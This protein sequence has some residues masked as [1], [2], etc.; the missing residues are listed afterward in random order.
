MI[1]QQLPQLLTTDQLIDLSLGIKPESHIEKDYFTS[2]NVIPLGFRKHPD[3]YNDFN[4]PEEDEVNIQVPYN[5]TSNPMH[6]GYV[7][8]SGR[9]KT[10]LCKNIALS[11]QEIGY[12]LLTIEAKSND[13]SFSRFKGNGQILH[14]NQENTSMNCVNYVPSF[15]G[16]LDSVRENKRN[17]KFY[18]P[19]IRAFTNLE[20]WSNLGISVIA[21]DSVSAFLKKEAINKKSITTEEI[22]KE[23][24]RNLT[25]AKGTKNS[26]LT[27]L[28]NLKNLDFFSYPNINFTEEWKK[29]RNIIVSLYGQMGGRVNVC[30]NKL[31][32]DVASIGYRER[33]ISPNNVSGKFIIFEDCSFYAT[34]NDTYVT[35]EIRNV[36]H[37]MRA[38]GVNSMLVIQLPELVEKV[39]LDGTSVKIVGSINNP[40][41]IRG[42][43]PKQAYEILKNEDLF[44]DEDNFIFEKLLIQGSRIKRFFQ[45]DCRCNHPS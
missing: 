39:T 24:R 28:S 37:N 14:R 45:W 33:S 6:I 42:Q 18:S 25:M 1:S 29:R 31:I 4:I 12:N 40:E 34:A 2:K 3:E 35:Q 30:V 38:V 22:E 8:M 7:D 10:Q 11:L 17:L 23:I 41:A 36:H 43:I 21:S 20:D 26:A 16:D 27:A 9:R 19:S 5:V 13:W 32:G 15:L 44:V